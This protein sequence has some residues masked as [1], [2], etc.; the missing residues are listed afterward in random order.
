MAIF[1]AI[2]QVAVTE[3]IWPTKS[4]IFMARYKKSLSMPVL[5]STRRQE[6]EM[7]G[8]NIEKEGRD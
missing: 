6:K 4:K 3:T 8:V 2:K 5:N 1:Y 7:K